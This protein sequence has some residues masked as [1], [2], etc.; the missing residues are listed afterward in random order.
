MNK[1]RSYPDDQGTYKTRSGFDRKIRTTKVWELYVRWKDGS[2][3]WIKMKGLKDS[4]PV[5]LSD[6]SVANKL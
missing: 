3:D 4:Y 1:Q 2:G 6:Y 5:P